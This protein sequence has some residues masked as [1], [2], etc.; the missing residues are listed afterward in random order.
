MVEPASLVRSKSGK[1]AFSETAME[2]TSAAFW[3]DIPMDRRT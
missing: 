3:N 1:A 2:P